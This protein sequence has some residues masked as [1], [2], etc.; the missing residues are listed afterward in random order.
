MP[1]HY[2]GV[3]LTSSH[4]QSLVQFLFDAF[5]SVVA[6]VLDYALHTQ[7]DPLGIHS[8]ID[9]LDAALASSA[10]LQDA[11]CG[12]TYWTCTASF[13]MIAFLLAGILFRSNTFVSSIED[14][15]ATFYHNGDR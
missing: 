10:V 13:S 1:C 6:G 15:V 12:R 7:D 5:C 9:V 8:G 14:Y 3:E 11:F 2:W 4:L